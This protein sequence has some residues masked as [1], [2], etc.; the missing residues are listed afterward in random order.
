MKKYVSINAD[1][2]RNLRYTFNSLMVLEEHLDRPISQ[3]GDGI[4]FKDIGVLVWA[5]LLHEEPTLT[6]SGTGAIIDA[7]L[8]NE[9]IQSLMEKV[10]QAIECAFGNSKEK[11]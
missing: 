1:K 2:M 8:E 9:G 4:K 10:G 11:K 6:L 5:G 7:V 3:L